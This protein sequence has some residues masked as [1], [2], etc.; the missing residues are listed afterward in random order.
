MESWNFHL[1]SK[2]D[3]FFQQ[4]ILVNVICK[5]TAIISDLI[6]R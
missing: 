1:E 2:F 5:M 6:M 3:I 4:N